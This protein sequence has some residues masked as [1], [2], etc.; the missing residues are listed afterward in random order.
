[1]KRLTEFLNESS[2]QKRGETIN[3]YV[4]S[5]R[6]GT[7][8][9]QTGITKDILATAT[10]QQLRDILDNAGYTENIDLKNKWMGEKVDNPIDCSIPQYWIE[11]DLIVDGYYMYVYPGKENSKYAMF[12][13]VQPRKNTGEKPFYH[14][15]YREVTVRKKDGTL[16]NMAKTPSGSWT[17]GGDGALVDA[18]NDLKELII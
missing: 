14:V 10:A 18:A 3:E 16:Y 15:K 12:V 9:V 7:R 6:N 17:A 8:I 11:P 13:M 4:S 1:M 2:D 5:G